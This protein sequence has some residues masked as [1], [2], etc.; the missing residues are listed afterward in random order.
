MMGML[1]AQRE[2]RA[3]LG[4]CTPSGLQGTFAFFKLTVPVR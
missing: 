1:Q 4:E 3:A 2:R